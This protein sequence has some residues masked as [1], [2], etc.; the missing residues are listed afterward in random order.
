MALITP[1][2][3]SWTLYPMNTLNRFPSFLILNPS[4]YKLEN[5]WLR[6]FLLKLFVN[7]F[8]I[9]IMIRRLPPFLKQTNKSQIYANSSTGFANKNAACKPIQPPWH[10]LK[11]Y[12]ANPPQVAEALS[13]DPEQNAVTI[14]TIHSAKGL[15]KRVVCLLS[16][17]S[18]STRYQLAHLSESDKSPQL[19]IK[20]IPTDRSKISHP[21]FNST[22]KKPNKFEIRIRSSLLCCSN[23]R[24]HSSSFPRSQKFNTNSGISH[25]TL[26]VNRSKFTDSQKFHRQSSNLLICTTPWL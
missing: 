8:N 4:S 2:I 11:Q 1:P 7:G 16:S 15:S 5:R 26:S 10:A 17:P 20:I 19:S 22:A 25:W 23:P 13:A 6:V 3:R 24:T 9:H 12:I 18:S 21:I 14:M